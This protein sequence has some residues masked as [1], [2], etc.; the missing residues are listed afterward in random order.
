MNVLRP[1]ASSRWLRC[2]ASAGF[3]ER[4]ADRIPAEA[5]SPYAE[6]GTLAHD[7]CQRSLTDE[8]F[9]YDEIEDEEM[10]EVVKSYTHHVLSHIEDFQDAL[11]VESKVP[12]LYQPEH[13]GTVDAAVIREDKIFIDDLKYGAG[14]FVEAE[15]N[16]QLTIYAASLIWELLT[17]GALE[18]REDADKLPVDITIFQPR[19]SRIP[20]EDPART[21]ETTV[22]EVLRKGLEIKK[23]AY[24]IIDS[25]D[26]GEFNP[27]ETA[28]HWCPAA[29]ICTAKASKIAE[30]F[31]DV[32]GGP[33]QTIIPPANPALPDVETLTI[34]QIAKLVTV[35]KDLVKWMDSVE[36]YAFDLLNDGKEVPGFKLVASKKHRSWTS[37]K[38]A[39]VFLKGHLPR[40]ECYNEKIISP[41]QAEKLLKP[42]LSKRGKSRLAQITA[43]GDGGPKLAPDSDPREDLNV[44]AIKEFSDESGDENINDLI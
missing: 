4:N 20:G 13:T 15:D 16:P 34:E 14:I 1:S 23:T 26:G 40:A 35:K 38:E 22:G 17:T 24:G 11:M 12:L 18:K 44:V 36:A 27:S 21:W 29:G 33:I 9:D 42:K 10:R 3:I 2:T 32:S 5:P 6:E 37:E 25:P 43:R 7:Y 31:E 19:C 39:A 30:V 28:C 41:T 8:D